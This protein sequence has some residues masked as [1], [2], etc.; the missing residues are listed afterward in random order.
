[1]I[2]WLLFYF[3]RNPFSFKDYERLKAEF[4]FQRFVLELLSIMG[5]MK[6]EGISKE[7]L[8]TKKVFFWKERFLRKLLYVLLLEYEIEL[9]S[10]NLIDFDDMILL[11]SE[12]LENAPFRNYRYILVEPN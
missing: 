12:S 11:A 10:Q 2:R 6:A 4:K 1:M 3:H 9:R 7:K 8:I 5:K